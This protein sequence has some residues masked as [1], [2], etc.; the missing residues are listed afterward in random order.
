MAPRISVIMA[1]YNGAG[2]VTAAVRSV[3][4]QTE[5][6]LELIF[7]DDGSDDDSLAAAQAAADGD[8]RFLVLRGGPRSRAIAPSLLHKD[9]G[10]PSSTA[11]ITSSPNGSNDC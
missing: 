6:N 11:T 3:L 4:G 7:S 1:N 9:A 2:H 8:S 5:P 10:S